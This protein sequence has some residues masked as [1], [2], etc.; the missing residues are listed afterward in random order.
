MIISLLFLNCATSNNSSVNNTNATNNIENTDGKI[1]KSFGSFILPDDWVEIT[2]PQSRNGWSY[3][4]HKSQT[5][6]DMPTNICISMATNPYDKDD[7]TALGRAISNLL[8]M[9]TRGRASINASGSY[10]EQGYPLLIFTIENTEPE[11]IDATSIQ[12]YIVDDKKHVLV[13]L[14]DFHHAEVT[15]AKEIARNIVDSFVWSK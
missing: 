12:F 2:G 13:Y 8:T 14:T 6:E 9:Q 15:D 11:S 7:P 1:H 3:Y 5:T 10:T 4:V